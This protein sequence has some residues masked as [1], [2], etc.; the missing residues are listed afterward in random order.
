MRVGNPASC[1][2][3]TIG[4][5]IS[6]TALFCVILFALVGC[7]NDESMGPIPIPRPPLPE[8]I[9]ELWADAYEC[10]DLDRYAG[11]LAEGYVHTF[12]S[13]G[14]GWGL[15]QEDSLSRE[16]DLEWARRLFENENVVSIT[17]DFPIAGG[18]WPT[19][20]GFLFRLEPFVKVKVGEP[21]EADTTGGSWA[22]LKHFLAREELPCEP[23]VY[24]A[25]CTW[26]DVELTENPVDTT[27]WVISIIQES[28]K[29]K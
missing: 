19:E 23:C 3:K 1:N 18:P 8:T 20:V 17:A 4:R 29:L 14:A 22:E 24:I 28:I 15:P 21:A 6:G 9:F 26:L 12:P 10:R 7:G 2:S 11:C 16:V 27:S 25:F 5:S 13:S